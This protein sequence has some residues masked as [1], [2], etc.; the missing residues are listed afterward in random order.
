MM[1]KLGIIGFPLG[2][3]FSAGYFAEKFKKLNL[4]NYRYDNYPIESIDK[5]PKLLEDNPGLIGFNVTIPYKEAVIP[6]L[7]D[8]SDDASK[9]GAVNVVKISNVNGNLKLTG[10]NSDTYGFETPLLPHLKEH[11]TNALILG[12]GGAAKAVAWVLSK[13]QV[14][15]TYVS[16]TPKMENSISY[17]DIN[18]SVIEQNKLIINT[19]PLGM[20][21]NIETC[22]DIP[23]HFLNKQHILYDLVYNPLKTKFLENGE[24]NGA[25]IIHGLHMLEL[26]ADKAWEIWNG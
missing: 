19:S 11:H 3:S 16:R 24:N 2:H 9:I 10:Y 15:Y 7:D 18:Q 25:T 23:Y 20:Y 5:L 8:L 13:N 17:S 1:K 21:P 4:T 22:A 14:N 26:Q 12:T 6:F